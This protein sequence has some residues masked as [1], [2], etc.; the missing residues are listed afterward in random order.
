MCGRFTIFANFTDIMNRFDIDAGIQEELY[1]SSYNIAPS[2][3]VLSVINDGTK[4]RLGYLRWGLVPPWTK[5]EKIGYKLINARA[6]TLT[7]KSSFR[8]RL[9][10]KTLL[11]TRG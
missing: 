4:N 10:K 7:E 5:D 11:N 1:K 9:P 3:S 8:Q 2:N 6:E